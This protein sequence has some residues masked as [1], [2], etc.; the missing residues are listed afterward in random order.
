MSP[1]TLHPHRRG[2]GTLLVSL[3]RWEVLVFFFYRPQSTVKEV[4]VRDVS[5]GP[6][7][8]WGLNVIQAWSYTGL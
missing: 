6:R 5:L 2:L 1:I 4:S 3:E 8:K 7:Q